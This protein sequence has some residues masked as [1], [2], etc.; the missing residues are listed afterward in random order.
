MDLNNTI[1]ANTH[2]IKYV[3]KTWLEKEYYFKYF[4]NDAA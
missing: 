1:V 4:G 2:E 3:N